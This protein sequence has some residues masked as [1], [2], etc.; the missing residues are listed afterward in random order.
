MLEPSNLIGVE[1]LIPDGITHFPYK[2]GK[3]LTWDFTC[4]DTVCDSYVLDSAKEA[5]KAAKASIPLALALSPSFWA[6]SRYP[7]VKACVR[8]QNRDS[9]SK[10]KEFDRLFDK[11]KISTV[12]RQGLQGPSLL[13][14]GYIQLIFP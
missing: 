11:T 9:V 2:Q 6:F 7:L 10:N 8:I 14:Q 3:S 1:G 13:L 4:V 5:G 12:L